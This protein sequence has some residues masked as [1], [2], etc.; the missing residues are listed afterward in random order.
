MSPFPEALPH[1]PLEEIF[2]DVF[3]VTGTIRPVYGD[4][5]WQFSRN[6]VV[7]RQDQVLTIINSVRLSDAGLAEMEVLGKVKHVV[8]LGN[9]HGVDDAFYL[10]RYHATYW[11]MPGMPPHKIYPSRFLKPEGPLPLLDAQLFS[12]ETSAQPEG[13]LHL[14]AHG[15]LLIACDSLQNW[16]VAD[17]YFDDASREKMTAFGF[18]KKANIGPGWLRYSE[19]KAPDFLRLKQLSFKHLLSA[20]GQPLLNTAYE[21]FSARI[22]E[23]FGV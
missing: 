13:L 16:E 21:D 22:A 10:D 18:I 3:F 12:F 19:P 1:G 23:V 4:E 20:H 2:P 14:N 15:G 9:F 5:T 7:L 6:M 11:Q 17:D 8:R